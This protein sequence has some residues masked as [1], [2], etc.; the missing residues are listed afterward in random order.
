L[1][2]IKGLL[3]SSRLRP[4]PTLPGVPDSFEPNVPAQHAFRD[5]ARGG[6]GAFR[7]AIPARIGVR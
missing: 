7:R 5:S 4:V 3:G 6:A 2:F 1:V